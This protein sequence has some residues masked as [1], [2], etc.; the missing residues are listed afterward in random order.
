MMVFITKASRSYWYEIRMF[1]GMEDIQQFIQEC[2]C[3]III[4]END[5]LNDEDFDFWKDMKAKDIP[6][7][8][9]CPLH[10]MIYDDYVE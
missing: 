5:Y 6:I 4:E 10:I 7:I 9:K 1:N 3:G 8:K 2:H